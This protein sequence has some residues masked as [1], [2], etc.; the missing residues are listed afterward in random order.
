MNEIKLSIS[1]RNINNNNTLNHN[2][3][4]ISI[5]N[6]NNTL[7]KGGVG[8][9]EV[10]DNNHEEDLVEEEAKLYAIIMGSQHTFLEI[11]KVLRKI[12]HIVKNLITLSNSVCSLFRNGKIELSLTPT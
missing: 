10:E 7:H 2:T 11:V 9:L 1:P 4:R 6:N 12:V 8:T 5:L 3:N